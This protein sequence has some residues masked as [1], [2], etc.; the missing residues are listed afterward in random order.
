MEKRLDLDG[1]QYALRFVACYGLYVILLVVCVANFI[2]WRIVFILGVAVFLTRNIADEAIVLFLTV[3][4]GL[5]LFLA[6][7][8]WEPRLRATIQQG[9]L[10][11]TFLRGIAPL[12]I[13][14]ALGMLVGWLGPRLLVGGGPI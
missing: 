1:R 9:R 7:L 6:A 13:A 3:L 12:A 11:P 14:L 8:I 10:W 2:I 5:A 4:L